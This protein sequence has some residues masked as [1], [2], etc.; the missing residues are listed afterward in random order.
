MSVIS[1][2]FHSKAQK[3][4]TWYIVAGIVTVSLALWAFIVSQFALGVLAILFAGVFLLYDINSNDESLIEIDDQGIRLD[5]KLYDMAKIARFGV[6]YSHNEPFALR[7]ITG[8]RVVQVIDV[9]I[10]PDISIPDLRGYLG[11]YIVED[12]SMELSFIENILYAL[13]IY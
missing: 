5:G 12:E 4:R 2:T 11:Q 7:I 6:I 13:G 1:W 9:F 3:T 8:T 10:H